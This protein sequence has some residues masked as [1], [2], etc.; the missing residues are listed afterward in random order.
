MS[1]KGRH[2]NCSYILTTH[3]YNAVNRLIRNNAKFKLFFRITTTNELKSILED[4]ESY[5]VKQDKLA[6]MIDSNTGNHKSF[7]IEAGAD[8]DLY[9]TIKE[10][11]VIKKVNP[12]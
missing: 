3:K 6:K 7:L 12:K 2:Y 4:G 1:I 8:G 10:D 9:Y 11:G 5:H